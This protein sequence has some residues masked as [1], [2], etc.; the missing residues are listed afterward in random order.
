MTNG[1]SIK[2]TITDVSENEIALDW[3]NLDELIK[4]CDDDPDAPVTS[5]MVIALCIQ[6]MLQAELIQ[7]MS[8]LVCQD[9]LGE[10]R[11]RAARKQSSGDTQIISAS[12]DGVVKPE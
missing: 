7:P 6:R 3:E 10:M 2:L 9:I 5:S 12:L 1:P 11:K 8:M 4:D